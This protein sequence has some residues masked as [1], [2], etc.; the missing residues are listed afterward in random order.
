MTSGFLEGGESTIRGYRK[1]REPTFTLVA[2]NHVLLHSRSA[3]EFCRL[4]GIELEIDD[5]ILLDDKVP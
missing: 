5:A 3:N 4:R 2:C 1:A